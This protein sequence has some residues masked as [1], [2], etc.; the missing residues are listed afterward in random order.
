MDIDATQAS[1]RS[2]ERRRLMALLLEE[3]RPS[4]RRRHGIPRRAD[5]SLAPLSFAQ[6]RIWLLN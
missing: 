3:G 1:L 6:R 5:P 2:P 4:P